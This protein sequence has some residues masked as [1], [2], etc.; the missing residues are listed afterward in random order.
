MVTNIIRIYHDDMAH[1]GFEK[2]IRANF[3]EGELQ[4]TDTPFLPFEIFHMDHFGP[5]KESIDGYKHILVTV[6]AFS[7]FTW[8]SPS[9]NYELE[10]IAVAAP[11]ANGLVERINRFLKSS[12][13]EL[14]DDHECWNVHLDSVQYV[15]NNTY[16]ASLRASPSKV[17][18]GI[19]QRNNADVKLI[20]FLNK[21]A[22]NKLEFQKDR[23]SCRELALE[24][25]NK[26]KERFGC[27][28]H[29]LDQTPNK[30]KLEPRSKKGIFV[31]Y[32]QQLKGYRVWIPSE[33]KVQVSRD[34]KFLEMSDQPNNLADDLHLEEHDLQDKTK[35][36][37]GSSTPK[38]LDEF[39]NEI[40]LIGSHG[41]PDND[42]DGASSI[43]EEDFLSLSDREGEEENLP[44]PSPVDQPD[45]A[46][47]GLGRPQ[48]VLSGRPGRPRK[49]YQTVGGGDQTNMAFL[50]EIPVDRALSS[51][52]SEEWMRAIVEEV[53]AVLKNGTWKL[54]KRPEG[55]EIVGSG[56]VLQN[57][58]GAS[59]TLKKRKARVV[60]RGFSQQPSRDFHETYAPVARLSSIRL[61]MAIAARKWM[62]IRQ[63]DVKTA[64]LNGTLEKEVYMEVPSLMDE[65]LRRIIEDE[66][67]DH[68]VIA[69]VKAMLNQLATGD[70]VCRMKKA[71]Y[72]L[73]QAGHA[74]H[75]RLDEELRSL[76][77]TPSKGDPCLYLKDRSG[78]LLIAVVYVDDIIVMSENPQAVMQFGADLS[79]RFD[80]KDVGK[81][82]RCLGM[83]FVQDRSGI[84]IN[85]QTYITDLIAFRD[86]GWQAGFDASRRRHETDEDGPVDNVAHAASLLS[87]F[88]DCFAKAHWVVAK[89]VLRYLKG[90]ANFGNTYK[91]GEDD[92][93]GFVDADWAG[94]IHDRRSFTGYAFVINGG[95]ISWYSKKQ[96]TV[97]LSST[98]AEYMALDEA[99]KEAVYLRRLLRELGIN[100]GKVTLSNDNLR[101]QRLATNPVFHART[102]HIDIRH[103]LVREIVDAGLIRLEHVASEEM[104]ADVLTKALTKPKHG[105]CIRLLE[106]SRVPGTD[107]GTF[108]ERKCWDLPTN[109][110][111]SSTV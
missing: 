7:R 41:R 102:K 69:E 92:F 110:C 1:C 70:Q 36:I 57:K 21:I 15:I 75:K 103:H 44:E 71:L 94:S 37:S 58:Y 51:P 35:S 25:I 5:I 23:D 84:R 33:G 32:S 74:W 55:R 39:S 72:G 80:M 59:E 12:L 54:V 19:E 67:F 86:A 43:E 81:L 28:L 9:Q 63:Y 61:T 82:K 87:Q 11:W 6:D 77:A 93:Q 66:Q 97:A 50:A 2:T 90:T 107:H 42:A 98:E 29:I 76:G 38:Y 31:G 88:N 89:R 106:L 22:H 79:K 60:V 65:I 47:R 45:I 24:A 14:V 46:R 104:P 100:T 64:Y 56:F 49:V 16:H 26:I 3:R 4:V 85:Q 109:V 68:R 78:R 30:S 111:D 62:F 40:Q 8:L 13:K 17:L 105:T 83:D 48:K 34:V 10:R 95:C 18:L 91:Y 99:A 108:I 96:R 52:E 27:E 53:K 20:D 73:K 101:A